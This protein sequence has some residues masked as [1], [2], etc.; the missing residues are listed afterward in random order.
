[1]QRNVGGVGVEGLLAGDLGSVEVDRARR[2]LEQPGG[3][4]CDEVE[5]LRCHG[6]PILQFL[7]HVAARLEQMSNAEVDN[8]HVI[9]V[10]DEKVLRFDVA[11][12]HLV[13]VHYTLT[14]F[15]YSV[16]YLRPDIMS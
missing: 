8:L 10:G 2:V 3:R 13:Q 1:M 5:G 15:R 11:M 14:A 7:L 6:K 9:V 16:Q 12:H 4:S